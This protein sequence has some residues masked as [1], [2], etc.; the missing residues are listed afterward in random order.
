MKTISTIILILFITAG[1]AGLLFSPKSI[2]KTK[3]MNIERFNRGNRK[4]PPVSSIEDKTTTGSVKNNKYLSFLNLETDRVINSSMPGLSFLKYKTTT[5]S[6]KTS[7]SLRI[8]SS[9][10]EATNIEKEITKRAFELAL[11]YYKKMGFIFPDL[12]FPKVYFSTPVN[13]KEN[14]SENTIALYNNVD[15]Y[16]LMPPFNSKIFQERTILGHKG[17]KE[18][19][20]SI[21][22]HEFCHYLNNQI[23]PKIVRHH[24]EFIACALQLAILPEELRNRIVDEFCGLVFKNRNDISLLAYIYTPKQFQ[25]A[26]YLFM[27]NHESQ[28]KRIIMKSHLA[29]RDPFLIPYDL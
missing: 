9:C 23:N 26:S 11:V 25:V 1:V 27:N 7:C 22:F 13:W 28:M 29:I 5:G 10:K 4:I 3:T 15:Q 21:L 17:N 24:D 6:V 19:Y 12:I 18:I 2:L 20:L 14:I 8:V 16:I